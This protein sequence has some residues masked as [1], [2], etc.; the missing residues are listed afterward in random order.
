MTISHVLVLLTQLRVHQTAIFN[1][2]WRRLYLF[3]FLLYRSLFEGFC[4]SKHIH[5]LVFIFNVL[6]ANVS[7]LLLLLGPVVVKDLN[8]EGFTT[9]L[10]LLWR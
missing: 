10:L 1:V 8:D 7:D 9:L 4:L 5:D 6:D 2:S 3:F